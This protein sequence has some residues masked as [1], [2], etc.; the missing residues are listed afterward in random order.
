MQLVSCVVN[1]FAAFSRVCRTSF[2]FFYDLIYK[3]FENY[4]NTFMLQLYFK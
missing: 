4:V 2:N 1:A 3:M